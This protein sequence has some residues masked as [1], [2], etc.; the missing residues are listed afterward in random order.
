MMRWLEMLA[1]R[2]CAAV[3]W[4]FWTSGTPPL[5]SFAAP[6][7]ET[8]VTRAVL[9]DVPGPDGR[10]RE[11]AQVGVIWPPGGDQEMAQPG[12][13]SPHQR[14]HL[15]RPGELVRARRAGSPITV[16]VVDGQPVA[17]RTD[18]NEVAYATLST[19]FAVGL[20]GLG[21]AVT[22][23]RLFRHQEEEPAR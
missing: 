2:G 18:L 11:V 5:W 17:N 22:L 12:L 13:I 21:L 20:T 23:G 16:R 6:R 1:G 4:H 10:T 3:A 19:M 14:R 15:H 9:A 8:I 7:A